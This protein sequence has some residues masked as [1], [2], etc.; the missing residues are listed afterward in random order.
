MRVGVSVGDF[1]SPDT[2]LSKYDIIVATSEKADS[3]LRHQVGMVRPDI[4]GRRRRG[5]P[6]Q[7]PGTGADPGDHADQVPAF[8]PDLQ[9]IALSATVNNS[10]E[11]ADWL[12]AEHISSEWRPIKLKEGV[13]L[14]GVVRFTD[15][16][17][18]KVTYDVD[19]VWS[20]IKDSHPGRGAVPGLRQHPQIHRVAGGQV[21]QTDEG[22]FLDKDIS[23]E[24]TGADGW[25]GGAHLR[26]HAPPVLREARDRL[27]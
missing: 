20:L 22:P 9:V 11:M 1:D 5:A 15:N 4:A 8:N 26:R 18:R 14:D 24:E 3:L 25:D 27:P 17:K 7:R 21:R 19:P 23:D 6:H 2:R 13:Y 12:Q 16:S 10:R